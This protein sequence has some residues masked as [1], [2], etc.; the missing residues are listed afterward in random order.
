M[1]LGCLMFIRILMHNNGHFTFKQYSFPIQQQSLVIERA[2]RPHVCDNL[3][4]PLACVTHPMAFHMVV[5]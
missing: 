3:D 5:I 2:M 1:F 4:T